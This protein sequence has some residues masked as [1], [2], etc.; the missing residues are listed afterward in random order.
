MATIYQVSELAGVSL[1]TV[2]R[3][4]NKNAR[5]SEKTT[6]TGTSP[7]FKDGDVNVGLAAVASDRV[8]DGPEVCV[9]A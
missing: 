2:S 6:A 9:H 5:V 7:S 4:M 1:A 8:T 3:V